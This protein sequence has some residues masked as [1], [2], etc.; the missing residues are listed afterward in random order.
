MFNSQFIHRGSTL[1]LKIVILLIGIG[2]LTLCSFLIYFS[3]T[4]EE[5]G[6]YRPILL[7]MCVTAIPFG[8]G[9]FQALK[10]LNYIDRNE[11]FSELSVKALNVIKINA[12]IISALYAAG[13]PYIYYV[14]EMDDAPGVILIGM[15]LVGAPAVVAVVV[16]ILIRLLQNAIHIKSENDLTV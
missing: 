15:V 6:A 14:A 1:F 11:A 3:I 2:A 8:I 5:V 10:L 16:A 4:S 9:L 7:G 13:M 12:I